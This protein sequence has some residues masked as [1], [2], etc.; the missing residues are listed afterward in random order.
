M[1]NEKEM[2]KVSQEFMGNGNKE[3]SPANLDK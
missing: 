3:D 2:R 1:I